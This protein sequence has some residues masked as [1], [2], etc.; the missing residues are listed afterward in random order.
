VDENESQ[1]SAESQTE[2]V[3]A[4]IT[5][6]NECDEKR[7]SDFGPDGGA[8]ENS[9]N[10]SEID[11]SELDSDVSDSSEDR[12]RDNVRRTS[13]FKR[14]ETLAENN[15]FKVIVKNVQ[16]QRSKNFFES[17]LFLLQVIQKVIFISRLIEICTFVSTFFMLQKASKNQPLVSSLYSLLEKALEK[18]L[19]RVKQEYT[20]P[21][22]QHQLYLTVRGSQIPKGIRTQNFSL[23]SSAN[24]MAS[25]LIE[26]LATFVESNSSLSLESSFGINIHILSLEESDHRERKGT[27][28]PHNITVHSGPHHIL[29]SE[30]YK[31]R[32]P[33][34]C[35]LVT[36]VCGLFL[37]EVNNPSISNFTKNKLSEIFK[38]PSRR[39]NNIAFA[40]IEEKI[41]DL[42]KRVPKLQSLQAP[43]NLSLLEDLGSAVNIQTICLFKQDRKKVHI[44]P[45]AKTENSKAGRDWTL[46]AIYMLVDEELESV[47]LI[48][49]PMTYFRKYG[50]VCQFCLKRTDSF[51]IYNHMCRIEGKT[52]SCF[53]CRR[54]LAKPETFQD[55]GSLDYCDTLMTAEIHQICEKCN[56]VLK[57]QS[58]KRE[59]KKV[60]RY[61]YFCEKCNKLE[62][63]NGKLASSEELRKAHCCSNKLCQICHE[64]YEERSNHICRFSD[65]SFPKNINNIGT[66]TL[67]NQ[68]SVSDLCLACNP[69]ENFFCSLHCDEEANQLLPCLAV[70]HF[71]NVQREHFKEVIFSDD[72]LKI[73]EEKLDRV[74][75]FEYLP[76]SFKGLPLWKDPKQYRMG[77]PK[78][79]SDQ[80]KQAFKKLQAKNNKSIAEKLIYC[81]C[82]ECFNHSIIVDSYTSME[83]LLRTALLLNFEVENIMSSGTQVRAFQIRGNSLISFLCRMEYFDGTIT[84]LSRTFLEDFEYH[85]IPEQLV[86]KK[87]AEYKGELPPFKCF[88]NI[89]D[90]KEELEE[91]NRF[92]KKLQAQNI[93]EYHL[94]REI[95]ENVLWKA[96]IL[97]KVTSSFLKETLLFEIK[98]SSIFKGE[99]VP[100][101]VISPYTNC[102][103]LPQYS[104]KLLLAYGFPIEKVYTVQNSS[105]KKNISSNPECIFNFFKTFQNK[106]H[107]HSLSHGKN[108]LLDIFK[109]SPCMPDAYLPPS[110]GNKGIVYFFNGC[111]IHAHY[112]TNR[113]CKEGPKSADDLFQKTGQQRLDEFER[114]RDA[115]K[116]RYPDLEFRTIWQCEF[117]ARIQRVQND[118]PNLKSQIDKDLYNF[119]QE[120]LPPTGNLVPR[121][122]LRSGFSEVFNIEYLQE[123]ESSKFFALDVTS[124]YSFIAMTEKFP[125]GKYDKIRGEDLDSTKITFKEGEFLYSGRVCYGLAQVTIVYCPDTEFPFLLQKIKSRNKT[126]I[127]SAICRTCAEK[128]WQSSC[129]HNLKQKSW[130]ATYTLAEI[131]FAHNLGYKFLFHELMIYK[132]SNYI[133]RGFM[134]LVNFEKQRFSGIP[135]GMAVEEYCRDANKTY[136]HLDIELSSSNITSDKS[137][138]AMYKLIANSG[139]HE[140]YHFL[141]FSYCKPIF[142]ALGKFSQDNSKYC[143]TKFAY[144]HSDLLKEFKKG[145]LADFFMLTDSICQ[146]TISNIDEAG[147][148]NSNVVISAY[149]NGMYA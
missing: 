130:S 80:F 140:F 85:F 2:E 149:V 65:I 47:D 62:Q 135:E 61:M 136:E 25:Q 105:G 72:F 22:K 33:N 76:F 12:E 24:S 91:K 70:L 97:T 8:P 115:F 14:A 15:S 96:N 82:L 125:T 10:D 87:S 133:L 27:L 35:L 71:E 1:I 64:R 79:A 67:L 78:S 73:P 57:S 45:F 50:Q 53:Q 113:K 38:K 66:I 108:K 111:T 102:I 121:D 17:A 31:Q 60:C 119:L 18:A 29:D 120:P 20:L 54:I 39:K 23:K 46:P 131:V 128:K 21:D 51:R 56:S 114:K 92:Y 7:L 69:M 3:Y 86:H 109:N 137:R 98:C 83:V 100:S 30:S 84:E 5:H 132:E 28:V 138:R 88:Q 13:L 34:K 116:E 93:S 103:S 4:S 110:E 75:T 58:C 134:S 95:M 144:C 11:E 81:I 129:C 68:N 44:F 147:P 118:Y 107:I 43:Y 141:T 16:F 48:K 74:L 126:Q 6:S 104:F 42:M 41:K 90:L 32:F 89:F 139:K 36:F 142:S 19:I 106:N 55:K 117:E 145:N 122:A 101:K 146:M 37:L 127:V 52:F 123:N 63:I 40:L 148:R 59:H 9:P 26:S 94:A 49:G 124:Q 77:K 99:N 112:Q 143:S